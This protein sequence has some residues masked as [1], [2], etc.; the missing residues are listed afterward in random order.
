MKK[1]HILITQIF[2]ETKNIENFGRTLKKKENCCR[3]NFMALSRKKVVTVQILRHFHARKLLPYK[4]YGTFTQE[5]CCRANFTALSRKKVVAV[6]I[7]R[8]FH[9]RKLLPCKFYDT[10]TQESC[11]R[12]NFTAFS[13]RKIRKRANSKLPT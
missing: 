11:C 1:V 7:L 9:A 6:Q 3:A 13:R 2:T 12:A 8:H 4:F 10:F 5:S